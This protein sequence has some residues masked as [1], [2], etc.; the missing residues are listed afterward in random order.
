MNNGSNGVVALLGR[1]FLSAIFIVSSLMH[2]ANFKGTEAFMASQG[3]PTVGFFLVMAIILELI[4]GLM[5]LLGFNTKLGAAM[6]IVFLLPATFI[7][8]RF[9]GL[10]DPQR[11][12]QMINFMKNMSILG[13]LLVIFALGPGPKSLDQ[14][15][16]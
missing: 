1:V 7:F 2:I 6:L 9:W 8:H 10:E 4:G 14:R 13:G 16:K 11:Q 3:M 12:M 5:V 15:N